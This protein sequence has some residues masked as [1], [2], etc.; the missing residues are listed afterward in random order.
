MQSG[1]SLTINYQIV[2]N[3]DIHIIN[4]VLHRMHKVQLSQRGLRARAGTLNGPNKEGHC[5]N[6][7]EYF[8]YISELLIK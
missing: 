4:G 5:I 6:I 2:I 7:I 1:N 3:F 8:F